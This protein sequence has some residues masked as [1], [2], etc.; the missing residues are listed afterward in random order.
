MKKSGA[1]HLAEPDLRHAGWKTSKLADKTWAKIKIL[2]FVLNLKFDFPL[3]M[4]SQGKALFQ[5]FQIIA[6]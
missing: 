2:K 5:Q 6:F 4:F 3:R 1:L